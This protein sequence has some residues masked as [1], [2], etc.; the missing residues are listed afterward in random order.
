MGFIKASI[1]RNGDAK[2]RMFARPEEALA[3]LVCIFENIVQK[4]IECKGMSNTE[5]RKFL[6]EILNEQLT[7]R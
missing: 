5:A 1:K 2:F 7:D 6:M 4:L 3:L